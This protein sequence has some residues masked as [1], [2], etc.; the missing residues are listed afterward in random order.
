MMMQG[1]HA[2][3]PL[4]VRPLE[5]TD[6][7]DDREGLSHEDAAH[8]NHDEFLLAE[9]GKKAEGAAKA[10][11]PHIA[12]ENLGGI[13][14]EPQEAQACTDERATENCHLAHP[15]DIGQVQVLRKPG[16]ASDVDE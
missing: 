14:V 15:G 13:S 11:G 6:L 9:K 1:S 8:H 2:E 7:Q 16:V 10:E 5:I 4:A 12:H 3:N